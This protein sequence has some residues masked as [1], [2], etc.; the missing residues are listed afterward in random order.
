[1]E[2]LVEHEAI[3][4]RTD[5]FHGSFQVSI[6]PPYLDILFYQYPLHKLLKVTHD[7]GNDAER[8]TWR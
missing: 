4:W 2:D 1:M 3:L 6:Y 8:R 7:P 5:E